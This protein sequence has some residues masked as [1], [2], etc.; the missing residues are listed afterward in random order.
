ME[1][2][3]FGTGADIQELIS[4]VLVKINYALVQIQ[5]PTLIAL[6][7]RSYVLPV[8]NIW[9]TLILE[10]ALTTCQVIAT[11]HILNLDLTKI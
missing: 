7:P 10:C 9:E 11:D 3:R 2:N 6:I 1:I 8:G 4:L 5:S